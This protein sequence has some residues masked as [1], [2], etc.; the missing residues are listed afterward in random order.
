MDDVRK[1]FNFL[2]SKNPKIKIASLGYDMMSFDRNEECKDQ[3]RRFFPGPIFIYRKLFLET[4][5][6]ILKQMEKEFPKNFIYV[7]IWGLD[8][9]I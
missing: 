1:I 9:L 8:C 4:I 6:R 3:L 2:I 5:T 7:P